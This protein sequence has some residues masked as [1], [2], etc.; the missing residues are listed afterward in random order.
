MSTIATNKRVVAEAPHY[1][2]N[3]PPIKNA[4]EVEAILPHRNPFLLVDKVIEMTDDYVVAIKNVTTV[5]MPK[6]AA[7][8]RSM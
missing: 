6:M 2:P 8:G 3:V 5:N 4:R 1:D 7:K